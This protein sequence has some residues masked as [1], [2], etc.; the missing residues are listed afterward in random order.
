MDSQVSAET[1]EDLGER[2]R[3]KWRNGKRNKE[4]PEE[5]RDKAR[6]RKEKKNAYHLHRCKWGYCIYEMGIRCYKKELF[7]KQKEL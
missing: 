5:N 6:S 2:Y 3:P 7:R 4:E 1:E